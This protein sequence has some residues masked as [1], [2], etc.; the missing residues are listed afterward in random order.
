MSKSKILI[1]LLAPL[2]FASCATINGMMYSEDGEDV[3]EIKDI[4]VSKRLQISIPIPDNSKYI[5]D[6]TIIFGEGERFTGVLYLL[7]DI[8]ADEVVEFY[9]VSM[10]DDGWSEIAIVRSDFVLMNF[11]KEDRFATIKV[12]RKVFDNSSSEVTVGP[13][14]GTTINRSLNIDSNKGSSN[15]QPFTIQ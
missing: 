10:R 5:T 3:S 2:V 7:H 9:R 11:D 4:S 15:E 8:S 13:K 1:A 14:T 12:N 6:K